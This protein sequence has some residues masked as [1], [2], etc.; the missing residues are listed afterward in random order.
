M[1]RE[2]LKN[3]TAG[4]NPMGIRKGIEK[5]VKAAIEELKAFLNQS[6][7]NNLSHKLLLFLQLTK[8]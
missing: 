7:A 2:G 3:V 5:A 4:A 6:K 1:I 8:K